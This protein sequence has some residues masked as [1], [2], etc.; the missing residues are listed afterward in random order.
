MSTPQTS[1]DYSSNYPTYQQF[2]TLIDPAQR[3]AIPAPLLRNK[4]AE[5]ALKALVENELNMLAGGV[6]FDEL[7]GQIESRL[8]NTLSPFPILDEFFHRNVTETQYNAA[9]R[10]IR[11]D[12]QTSAPCTSQVRFSSSDPLEPVEFTP[13]VRVSNK[14][15]SSN[16]GSMSTAS[17]SAEERAPETPPISFDLTGEEELISPLTAFPQPVPQ[18]PI[19]M[20]H[21]APFSSLLSDP[22]GGKRDLENKGRGSARKQQRR[23]QP[24]QEI[25]L[26]DNQK[27]PIQNLRL[28]KIFRKFEDKD[29][30]AIGILLEIH[31]L[32]P[33]TYLEAEELIDSFIAK[34]IIQPKKPPTLRFNKDF[35]TEFLTAVFSQEL[36]EDEKKRLYKRIRTDL[37]L[38]RGSTA[39]MVRH[40]RLP[41]GVSNEMTSSNSGST[42]TAPSSA[43]QEASKTLIDLTCSEQEPPTRSSDGATPS[44]PSTIEEICELFG[45]NQRATIIEKIERLPPLTYSEV[46]TVLNLFITKEILDRNPRTP[47]SKRFGPLNASDFITKIASKGFLTDPQKEELRNQISGLLTGRAGKS[48]S[49]IRT[50]LAEI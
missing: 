3:E 12:A 26:S 7:Q 40:Y 44:Q 34:E 5:I 43:E 42:S 48:F 22:V 46:K 16:S 1:F 30:S 32:K 31:K 47:T 41:T 27:I 23:T 6:L 20:I 33:F 9:L 17:S 14:T 15:V 10:A 45:N 13:P 37:Y 2:K 19:H 8:R 21:S 49:A 39:S 24:S 50:A 36:T 11:R 38:I 29:S 35:I 4:V 18:G 28:E 25:Q